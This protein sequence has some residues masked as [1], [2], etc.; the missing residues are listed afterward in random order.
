MN[1]RLHCA[2]C[3]GDAFECECFAAALEAAREREMYRRPTEAEVR[4]LMGQLR[5]LKGGALTIARPK[6]RHAMWRRAER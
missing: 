3:E 6:A 5:A 4:R 2:A 1:A